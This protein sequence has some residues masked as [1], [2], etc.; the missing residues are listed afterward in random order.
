[1][2]SC[3]VAF[4]PCVLN[5][6]AGK[7]VGVAV[8]RR[9]LLVE[10]DEAIRRVFARAL[11]LLDP[12]IDVLQ[13]GTVAA[14]CGLLLQDMVALVVTD[15]HLP[16]GTALDVLAAAQQCAAPPSVIVLSS[17]ALVGPT[18]LAAG[19]TEFLAKPVDLGVLMAVVRRLL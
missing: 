8:V 9:L 10:D 4:T 11:A 1:V 13:A 17:N 3:H 5:R 7:E 18:A 2:I 12:T 16:D 14:A 19:A 6:S 15:Y